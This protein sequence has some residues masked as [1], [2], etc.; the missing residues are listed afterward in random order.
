[1]PSMLH[2]SLQN[3]VRECIDGKIEMEKLISIGA[4]IIKHE[5]FMVATHDIC[6]TTI[7][8]NFSTTIPPIGAKSISDFIFNNIPYDLKNTNPINGITKDEIKLNKKSVIEE[9]LKGADISRI[10]EQAKKTINNW[11]LN[12]FYVIVNNQNRW[13]DEPE[14]IMKE[15]IEE[16]RILNKPI[17]IN[18]DGIVINTQIISI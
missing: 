3:K 17:E 9:L 2:L 10:R 16:C 12:R 13:L 8:N 7:I 1:M 14:L 15:L 5:Y 18:L 4:D 6:E 11:G